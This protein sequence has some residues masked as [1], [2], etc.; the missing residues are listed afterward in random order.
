M[1]HTPDLKPLLT[2]RG[3]AKS[4]TGGR[5]LV[6]RYVYFFFLD[7]IS[8]YHVVIKHGA[9][10]EPDIKGISTDLWMGDLVGVYAQIKLLRVLE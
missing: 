2:G 5:L 4:C 3:S 8:N 7:A 6:A 10:N 1:A 9:M